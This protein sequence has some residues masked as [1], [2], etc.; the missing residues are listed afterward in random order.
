MRSNRSFL[1]NFWIDWEVRRM[2]RSL[3]QTG[4][5]SPR[6][7][8]FYGSSSIR[9]WS[10]LAVD[11][12]D[13]SVVNLGFGGSTL[14]DCVTYFER[15]V[16]PRTPRSLLVYAGDNDLGEGRSVDDVVDSFRDLVGKVDDQLGPIPLAFLAIK[17]SP[18]RWP[19]MDA[20]RDANQRIFRELELRP[21]SQSIDIVEPMLGPDG[22][23]RPELYDDDELHLS[24]LGYRVWTEEVAKHRDF[25]FV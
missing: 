6:P 20:I 24:E 11:L 5:G 23:P 12:G 10:S 7:V 8:V 16:T 17:P 21:N 14:A 2:E 25:L 18:A 4:P 3:R 13:P 1:V 22:R 19:L 9:L 15:L